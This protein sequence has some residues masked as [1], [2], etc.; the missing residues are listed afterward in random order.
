MTNSA[1]S[2][3]IDQLKEFR[4][5]FPHE[6]F[7]KFLGNLY[8]GEYS[9]LHLKVI[10]L[11][12]S[13]SDDP[14]S[15]FN[16]HTVNQKYILFNESLSVLRGFMIKNFTSVNGA[17]YFLN[18]HQ[19]KHDPRDEA[20]QTREDELDEKLVH[21]LNNVEEQYYGFLETAKSVL[22]SGQPD[23]GSPDAV[24]PKVAKEVSGD[25]EDLEIHSEVLGKEAFLLVGSKKISIGDKNN[26]PYKLWECLSNTPLGSL[27]R[28]DL[29]FDETSPKK[30]KYVDDETL[31]TL[32]KKEI[33]ENRLGEMQRFLSKEGVHVTLVF[34]NQGKNVCMNIKKLK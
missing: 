24:S 4:V 7:T 34:S 14:L 30:G 18:V 2:S 32:K 19:N 5:R 26:V 29:V 25:S 20:L 22:Y 9:A 15:Q 27:K 33:L 13:S 28:T 3:D 11:Q 31:S 17:T 10:N 23:G 12:L 8:L 1:T 6:V 16:D 21:W